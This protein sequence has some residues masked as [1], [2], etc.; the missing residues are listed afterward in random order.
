MNDTKW[1]THLAFKID[2]YPL[3]QAALTRFQEDIDSLRELTFTN[4][5]VQTR[6]IRQASVILRRWICDNEL[7]QITRDT[8]LIPTF[9]VLDDEHIFAAVRE[10][11]HVKYYLSAGVKFAGSPIV[12][13]Y[14]S[15]SDAPA[16]WVSEMARAG[17]SELKLGKAQKKS[18]LYYEGVI[19]RFDEVIRFVA[20][21]MGGA[22]TSGLRNDRD[23]ALEDAS[24][25]MTFGGPEE[26][27]TTRPPS[28][29]HLPL[30][31]N[32]KNWMSGLHVVII[33]AATMVL[34]VRFNGEPFFEF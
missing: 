9:P 10:D 20:N 15:E 5:P 22:H 3:A 14:H 7:S 26:H 33:A 21:K 18:V 29:I 11:S 17:S 12:G 30:E 2:A 8:G 25:Y 34:N 16:D 31:P 13:V 19:Y 32:S 23:S 27:L 28:V 1:A 4:G 6:H 24:D